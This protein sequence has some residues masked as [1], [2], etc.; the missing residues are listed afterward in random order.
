MS[1]VKRREKQLPRTDEV[2]IRQTTNVSYEML[3]GILEESD[4]AELV[5][6]HTQ[7]VHTQEEGRAPV[8]KACEPSAGMLVMGSTVSPGGRFVA[9]AFVSPSAASPELLIVGC[10]VGSGL[11]VSGTALRDSRGTCAEEGSFSE[12]EAGLFAPVAAGS[13]ASLVC[14]LGRPEM[15]DVGAPKLVSTRS[16]S[17]PDGSSPVNAFDGFE[18]WS[19]AGFEPCEKPFEKPD[20]GAESELGMS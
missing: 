13:A 7:H 16:V 18:A 17:T 3:T 19:E 15:S 11:V 10:S 12:P 14:K 6:F 2:R 4:Y 20:D 9:E 5:L 1:K 8:V